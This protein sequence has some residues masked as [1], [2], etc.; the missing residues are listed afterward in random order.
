M[1]IGALGGCSTKGISAALDRTE[2]AD[3]PAYSILH[4]C[5]PAEV[6]GLERVVQGLSS[7]SVTQGHRVTV[8]AVLQ[9][10]ADASG[11]LEPLRQAGVDTVRIEVRGRGYLREMRAVG[12]LLDSL[13]P[14]I[15]HT[16]GYRV[17]LLHG[18]GAR[19]RG[20]ATVS[21][22]HGSSRMGGLSHLFEWF[23][24]RALRRFDGV[25]AV[26][27]PLMEELQERGVRQE[28]LHLVPNAWTPPSHPLSRETARA[29]LGVDGGSPVLGWIGRLI[30]IKG[31]DVFVDALSQIIDEDWSAVIIG[32]GPELEG[33]RSRVRGSGI[34]HRVRFTGSVPEAARF[35]SAFDLFVLS[36]R[37]EGTPM[38]L[39]EAMGAGVPVVATRVGGV[40][41]VLRDGVDGWLLPPED[42]QELARSL[43]EALS[44]ASERVARGD[45]GRSRVRAHY[46][47]T[48]WVQWHVAAYVSAIE[49]RGGRGSGRSR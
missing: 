44:D 22:L 47:R 41:H 49:Q 20:I 11:F 23:Q 15:L 27:Q 38:V 39:L 1:W 29:E 33:L 19:R 48:A 3:G 43:E 21:T 4:L 5:A 12:R 14:D 37:S 18:S 17:D 30:P 13:R 26:S 2:R 7:E 28:R 9:P 32:D 8:A 45:A 16:H 6:G 42:P 35:L 46:S 36:S 31:C 40:P 25:I 24:E 10:G 34:A